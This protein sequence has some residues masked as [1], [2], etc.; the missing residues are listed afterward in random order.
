MTPVKEHNFSI[1]S[2]NL[3]FLCFIFAVPLAALLHILFHSSLI[4]IADSEN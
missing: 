1:P 3:T 2:C 4:Q